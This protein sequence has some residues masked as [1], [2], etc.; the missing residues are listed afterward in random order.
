MR[1]KLKNPPN[2]EHALGF[3]HNPNHYGYL[4]V[5]LLKRHECLRKQ[6]HYLEKYLD[7][8]YWVERERINAI[9]KAK[10]EGKYTYMLKGREYLIPEKR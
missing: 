7:K 1:N 8:G 5:K 4:S 6:C 3:C 2:E 9:K 10:K